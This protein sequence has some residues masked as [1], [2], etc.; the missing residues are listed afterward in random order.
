MLH[1][2]AVNMIAKYLAN[3]DIS[4]CLCCGQMEHQPVATWVNGKARLWCISCF[5]SC[6]IHTGGNEC[7]KDK[8]VIRPSKRRV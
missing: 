6:R 7:V 8:Q 5:E 3:A 4:S 1:K 2:G